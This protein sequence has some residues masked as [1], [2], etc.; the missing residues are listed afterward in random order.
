MKKVSL[1]ILLMVCM[2]TLSGCLYPENRLAQNQ[3][4]YPDQLA[5]VQSAVNQY[6]KDTNGLLPIKTR[7]EKTPMYQRYPV[8]FTKLTPKYMSDAPGNAYESGG[9]F[10]YVIMDA[11]TNPTIKLIDLHTT[12]KLRDVKLQIDMYKDNNTYPAIKKVITDGVYMLNYKKMGFKEEPYVISPYSH[13]NLPIV[14]GADGQLYIDYS[15]DLY[16]QLKKSKK[17]YKEGDDI[18]D[19]LYTNSPF[20]P[21]YSLP[22]TVKNGEPVFKTNNH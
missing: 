14:M 3:V 16:E 21:A 8:D 2:F 17:Q 9:P 10:Q 7:D 15:V 13:K 4:P 22:Y 18:R 19:L 20:V 5:S 1:F 12:D 6:K 11:E